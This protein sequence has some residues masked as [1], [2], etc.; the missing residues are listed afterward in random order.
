M[1]QT[2]YK[3]PNTRIEIVG[4]LEVGSKNINNFNPFYSAIW[5]IDVFTSLTM[6]AVDASNSANHMKLK[7]NLTEH[8]LDSSSNTITFCDLRLTSVICSIS[9]YN[10]PPINSYFNFSLFGISD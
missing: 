8:P 3:W 1:P 9:L 5:A 2:P 7:L 4:Q 10:S 6:D